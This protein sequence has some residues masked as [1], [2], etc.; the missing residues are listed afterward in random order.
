MQHNS[1]STTKKL[2]SISFLKV[3]SST[4]FSF[5]LST[6]FAWSQEVISLQDAISEALEHNY[7]IQIAQQQVEAAQNQIYKG[8]AGMLPNITWN[9]NVTGNLSQ[10]NQVFLDDRKINRLGQSFSPNTNLGLNWTLY[11]GRRMQIQY[12]RLN[13]QGQQSQ[14]EKKLVIQNAIG[15]VMQTYYQIL[16]QKKSVEYLTTIIGYYNER[17]KITEER[18]QIGRGSKLDYL[19]SK[20]DLNTQMS[21][22][23]NA[24]NELKN[25]VVRLNSILGS[26]ADR[27]YTIS[28]INV[29][30]GEYQLTDLLAAAKS[31]N[32]DVILLNKEIELSILNQQEMESFRKTRI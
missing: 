11:D 29:L 6:G 19:Q 13:S 10:V 1:Y 12:E 9:T 28:E 2:V 25:A 18:W 20:A 3:I 14:L 5:I 31:S 24:E 8:N 4:F 21:S 27:T 32:R 15:N 23:V 30:T 7:G 22:L 26:P 16:R 17:L